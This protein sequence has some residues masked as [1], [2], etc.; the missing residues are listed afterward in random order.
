MTKDKVFRGHDEV[1]WRKLLEERKT[2]SQGHLVKE[3]YSQN[4]SPRYLKMS[5]DAILAVLCC[6]YEAYEF[7]I[8]TK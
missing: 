6:T 2:K 4:S 8:C 1:N 3:Y 7:G 5:N